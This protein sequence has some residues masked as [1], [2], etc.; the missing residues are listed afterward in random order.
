MY[1]K[2]LAENVPN[3]SMTTG[4]IS[5]TSVEFYN[6]LMDSTNEVYK[7]VINETGEVD[8]LYANPLKIQEGSS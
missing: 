7:A 2:C 5:R 8:L 1:G 3:K 4:G 6:A